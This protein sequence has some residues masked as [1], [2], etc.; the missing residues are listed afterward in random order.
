MEKNTE[1]NGLQLKIEEFIKKKNITHPLLKE[2]VMEFVKG[3]DR[4]FGNIVSTDQLLGR[5]DEN[6]DKITFQPYNGEKL[7]KYEGRIS[8]KTDKNE[9][10]IYTMPEELELSDLDK[11]LWD[12]F[13]KSLQ[14]S[15][16]D[17]ID[18]K[19]K[20]VKSALIK[21]LTLSAYTIKGKYGRG[22]KQIFLESVS[23]FGEYRYKE[24]KGTSNYIE[25]ITNYI[26]SKI[27]DKSQEDL[28]MYEFETRAIYMLSDKIGDKNVITSAWNSDKEVL[29]QAYMDCCGKEKDEAEKSFDEFDNDMGDLVKIRKNDGNLLNYYTKS[30]KIMEHIGELL[31]GK[32]VASRREFKSSKQRKSVMT[33]I[34]ERRN[35]GGLED[36]LNEDIR[37]LWVD[38]A[39]CYVKKIHKTL[40]Q[41]ALETHEN[42][43]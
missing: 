30:G 18:N 35:K 29:K 2:G 6:L 23:T 15:L 1:D 22:Q 25:A 16:V 21:G 26:S 11:G 3:H 7:E 33:D 37:K 4:I 9:I 28:N 17:E 32:T 20:K 5:L 27:E 12:T 14:K 19:K 42:E 10:T 34:D 41:V 40:N 39:T 43:K 8:D 38:M 36:V 24:T 13:N 31:D